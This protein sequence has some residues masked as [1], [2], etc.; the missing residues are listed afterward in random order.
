MNKKSLLAGLISLLALPGFAQQKNFTYKF[1]GQIRGD[2]F[3]NSRAN[4]EIV[5]GLFHLYPQDRVY[6][7]AGN[8]LNAQ[9]NGSFYLLYTR[10]GVDLGGPQIGEIKTSA[11]IET[12]F[13]GY[14]TNFSLLRIRHAYVQLAWKKSTL[15]AGQTWHPLFG[16]VFPEMLNLSTGAPFNGFSRAPQIRYRFNSG[17]LQLTGIAI[18][19]LQFLSMGPTGK[20]EAYIKNSCV[21]EFYAAADYKSETLQ[22]GAG[23]EF[24]SLVPR[25]QT[26]KDGLVYK[27]NERVNSVSFE[28]HA[29][30][31]TEDWNLSAKTILGSNLSHVCMLSGFGVSGE[32]MRTGERQYTPFRQTA[33]WVNVV[34]GRKWK[35]GL[36]AGYLRNLGAGKKVSEQYGV[37]LDV[38][39]LLTFNLHGAYELPHWR[40]GVEYSPSTAWYGDANAKGKVNPNRAVTNHR[41]TAVMMY[42]F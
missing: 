28:A 27:V 6:D 29:K 4:G 2:L 30:Y 36:F 35:Q 19:Q 23:V 39:Q 8:D 5:D 22:A 9:P 21:P 25:T 34:H 37:G 10:L 16:D 11:K 13:R 41:V 20:N 32:D 33:T 42:R 40:F 26:E 38:G 17:K 3:Y 7:A 1:Y 15:L 24:L 14:G 18:W 12:D 31:Q